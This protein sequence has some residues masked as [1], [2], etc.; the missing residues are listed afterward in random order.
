MKTCESCGLEF[1]PRHKDSRYCC[2]RCLWDANAKRTPHNKGAGKG[3]VD[4]RG[5]RWIYVTINGARVAQREHRYVMEQHLG[6]KLSPEE[7]V[8]HI[9]GIKS[10]NRIE[11][12]QV[13]D[14]AN[15]TLEHHLGSH[16]SDLQK[17]NMQVMANYRHEHERINSLN[18]EL[19]EAL[20]AV[21]RVAGRATV[22][23]DM[24]RAAISKATGE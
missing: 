22:E 1:T 18:N 2:K 23:F 16:R 3:W 11:N 10:D 17:K 15:H 7:L 24:A 5:Y 12:L 14:W 4:R 8:H 13:E 21:V 19:L 20:Q 9:N 6:R